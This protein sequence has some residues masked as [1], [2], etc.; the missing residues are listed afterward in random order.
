M[1]KNKKLIQQF[2]FRQKFKPDRSATWISKMPEVPFD[3]I[4]S[5]PEYTQNKDKYI[6]KGPVLW[7]FEQL[8]KRA[9]I[10]TKELY[11]HY[12]IDDFAKSQLLFNS[13]LIRSQR[14]EAKLLPHSP[15]GELYS[16]EQVR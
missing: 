3:S 9:P 11:E 7:I 15:E 8:Y 14:Y 4:A 1:T 13:Y 6:T 16:E 2:Y 5:D 10:N 12:L